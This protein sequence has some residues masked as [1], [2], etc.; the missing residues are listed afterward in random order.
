MKVKL[1]IACLILLNFSAKA[2]KKTIEDRIIDTVFKI[3]EVKQ[4]SNLIKK[5]SKGKHHLLL[6]TNGE[7]SKE[8]PYYWIKVWEDNGVTT[9]TIFD[10]FV[11]PKTFK[12][13]Y[14]DTVNDTAISLEEWRR[15]NKKQ[16]SN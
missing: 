3:K 10:F 5:E 13:E 8:T 4:M 2:Q 9:V 11:Y 14:Y 6:F 16:I 15:Q 1:F 12:I 7:P